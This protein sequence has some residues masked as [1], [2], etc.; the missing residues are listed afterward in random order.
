MNAP[1]SPRVIRGALCSRA[2]PELALRRFVVVDVSC[3]RFSLAG[4]HTCAYAPASTSASSRKMRRSFM[5]D[6]SSEAATRAARA[7]P[8]SASEA[9]VPN[10]QLPNLRVW[11]RPSMQPDA[12]SFAHCLRF[13]LHH[14]GMYWLVSDRRTRITEFRGFHFPKRCLPAHKLACVRASRK[15][16]TNE[17]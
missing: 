17:R 4:G 10:P 9:H 7:A 16:D 13:R 6:A 12:I 11:L 8:S 1:T 15:T 2:H 3:F 14:H 5:S